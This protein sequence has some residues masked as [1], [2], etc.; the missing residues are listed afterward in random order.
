MLILFA[1]LLGLLNYALPEKASTKLFKSERE[2]IELWF[3][4]HI[5]M[6]SMKLFLTASVCL[7]PQ[8]VLSH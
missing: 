1:L 6:R 4:A 5:A 7:K 8:L 2:G 3:V